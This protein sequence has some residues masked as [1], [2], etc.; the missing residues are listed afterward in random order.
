MTQQRLFYGHWFKSLFLLG[1]FGFL[2]LFAGD[3]AFADFGGVVVHVHVG[4]VLFEVFG[5]L[6]LLAESGE[7]G[8]EALGDFGVL[9]F[10]ELVL[11]FFGVGLE[12]VEFP[13]FNVIKIHEFVGKEPK[14]VRPRN[15]DLLG[16]QIF[17]HQEN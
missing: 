16:K 9:G 2:G 17:L 10:A 13:F 1:G 7:F 12:V 15:H 3:A 5:D 8:S 11:H 14:G 6:V 4:E